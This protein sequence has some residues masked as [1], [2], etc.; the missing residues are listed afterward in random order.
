MTVTP[1]D[2]LKDYRRTKE[3][4]RRLETRKQRTGG[5]LDS[6]HWI[7]GVGD[8]DTQTI[9]LGAVLFPPINGV[10]TR[11]ITD[12]CFAAN[13]GGGSVDFHWFLAGTSVGAFTGPDGEPIWHPFDPDM[14]APWDTDAAGIPWLEDESIFP[15]VDT[16]TMTGAL[17]VTAG[18]RYRTVIE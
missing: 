14:G 4:V 6:K 2:F 1:N 18:V 10:G 16:S 13:F 17:T 3:R 9:D 7:I 12:W 8:V 15:V 5:R 11:Y